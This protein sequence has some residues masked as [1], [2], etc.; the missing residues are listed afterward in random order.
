M[1][2]CI[3][4][5]ARDPITSKSNCCTYTFLQGVQPKGRASFGR[6]LPQWTGRLVGHQSRLSEFEQ[7]FWEKT[8]TGGEPQAVIGFGP[9]H[10]DPVYSTGDLCQ[11]QNHHDD[12]EQDQTQNHL[13]LVKVWT[14]SKTCSE[15]MTASAD[16]LVRWW[17]TRSD[18]FKSNSPLSSSLSS[19]LSLSLPSSSLSSKKV[20]LSPWGGRGQL[21]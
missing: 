12:G 2:I 6:V 5:A 9:C 11:H 13:F 21:A 1:V 8:W 4:L 3:G 7:L 16:G 20:T 15:L 19:S 18:S 14:A 17:D 10:T